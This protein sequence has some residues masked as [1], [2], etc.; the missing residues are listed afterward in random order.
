M[1]AFVLQQ[2]VR[3]VVIEAAWFEKPKIFTVWPFAE[4]VSDP[5]MDANI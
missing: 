3:I 4:D 1:A 5:A 2:Q